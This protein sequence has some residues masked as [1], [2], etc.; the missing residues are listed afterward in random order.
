MSRYLAGLVLIFGAFCL[1]A[2]ADNQ[3]A[4]PG[5]Y[6]FAW[7]GDVEKQGNDFLA[8]IDADPHSASYGQLVTSVSTDQKSMQVH[9]TE[10]TM[11]E[12]GMPSANDHLAGRTFIFDLRDPLKP[13]IAGS[14]TEMAGYSHPHS[15]LRLPN[16]HVLVSFQHSHPAGMDMPMGNT[17]GSSGGI[18]EIDNQGQVVRSASSADP[19]F[20]DALL[21]PY[22]L[23]LLPELSK[24]ARDEFFDA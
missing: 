5:H 17:R 3:A 2:S 8:V 15:F 4:S 19:A 12:E 11:P 9:H 22:S 20:P 6:L 7:A 24:G 13:K 21:M 18:V 1:P 16:G 10:Y 14:F 23:V